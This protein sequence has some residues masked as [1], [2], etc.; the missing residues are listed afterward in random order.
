MSENTEL[1]N[2]SRRCYQRVISGVKK[3]G[4]LRFLTLT[5]SVEAPADIQRSFHTLK[6]RIDR[7]KIKFAYIRVTE[8]TKAGRKHLHIIF[9]GDYMQQAMLS[10]WWNE[11]H[12]SPIVDIRR[13][14]PYGSPKRLAG[15]MAKYMSK[16]NAGRL[17]WSWEWVWRGFCRDWTTYKSWWRLFIEVPGKTTFKNCIYGWDCILT[18]R[19]LADFKFMLAQCRYEVPFNTRDFFPLHVPASVYG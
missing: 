3:G 14:K 10:A 4:C 13:V 17:S 8:Y 18:G 19:L 11:I 9:R 1:S 15:Y 2:K 12:Q 5:S 7:R 6:A 16:D